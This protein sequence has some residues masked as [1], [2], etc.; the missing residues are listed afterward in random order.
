MMGVV[1]GAFVHLIGPDKARRLHSAHERFGD[2]L[3]D[4]GED[5]DPHAAAIAPSVARA[6]SRRITVVLLA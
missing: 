3:A 2:R 1:N 6:S 4:V 5:R